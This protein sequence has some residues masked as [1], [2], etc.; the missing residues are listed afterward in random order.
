MLNS[1][2][3]EMCDSKAGQGYTPKGPIFSF[4]P[5]KIKLYTM[6]VPLF[7]LQVSL[8]MNFNMEM[9]YTLIE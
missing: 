1:H 7:L 8:K 2:Q 4:A 9:S 5:I 6:K 3:S